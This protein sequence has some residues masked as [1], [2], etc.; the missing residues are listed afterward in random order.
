MLAD[1][2]AL[3]VEHE[4]FPRQAL[5]RRVG[6]VAH[7]PYLYEDLTAEENLLFYGRMFGVEEPQRRV[8]GNGVPEPRTITRGIR[9]SPY[10]AGWPYRS[11]GGS[12]GS[13][14]LCFRGP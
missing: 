8:S 12:I 2:V 4:L 11:M 6:V 5:R 7:H 14:T 1:K 10:S 9:I 3:N 13:L